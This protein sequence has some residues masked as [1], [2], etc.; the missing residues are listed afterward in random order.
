MGSNSQEKLKWI[1]S[2]R[3]D[4]LDRNNKLKKTGGIIFIGNDT[5]VRDGCVIASENDHTIIGNRVTV[6]HMANINSCIL[7]DNCVIG[8]GSILCTGSRVGK[9]S[10]LEP[11]TVIGNGVVVGSREIWCGNPGKKVRNL[12]GVEIEKVVRQTHEN[13]SLANTHRSVMNLGGKISNNYLDDFFTTKN[14]N[15]NANLK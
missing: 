8:M 12:T 15:L 4:V 11:G 5:T 10:I 7:E 1:Y 14:I 2:T 9:L 13:N 6:G 3:K